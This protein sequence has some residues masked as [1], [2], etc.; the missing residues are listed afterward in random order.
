MY[1]AFDYIHIILVSHNIFMT[2][3]AL[4]KIHYTWQATYD[5]VVN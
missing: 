2:V 3:Y 1:A 4:I 5:L